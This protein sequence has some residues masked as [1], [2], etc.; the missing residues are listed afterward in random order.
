LSKAPDTR[1]HNEFFE[2]CNGSKCELNKRQQRSLG[3]LYVYSFACR[4]NSKGLCNILAQVLPYFH[5]DSAGPWE[6]FTRK[7]II[8]QQ[9]RLTVVTC[10][11][12]LQ[13]GE[14]CVVRL[15]NIFI[16]GR[17]RRQQVE[18]IGRETAT[19]I[20]SSGRR[21]KIFKEISI[22][23]QQQKLSTICGVE[24]EDVIFVK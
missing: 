11:C 21:L 9:S 6:F 7:I 8:I 12:L 2:K 10:V 14:V 20:R 19:G 24:E 18:T 13:Q 15:D 16:G 23:I 5:F 3:A 1:N 17:V 4:T 22:N